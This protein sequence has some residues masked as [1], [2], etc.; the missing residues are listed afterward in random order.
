MQSNLPNK[1]P[2]VS[3]SDLNAK[4]AEV[5]ALMT[6]LISSV[7]VTPSTPIA[8]QNPTMAVE[9]MTAVAMKFPLGSI[10]ALTEAMI[11]DPDAVWPTSGEMAAMLRDVSI[12]A[13]RDSGRQM[14]TKARRHGENQC[15]NGWRYDQI[16][17][18][19]DQGRRAMR[20]GKPHSFLRSLIEGR[21]DL[22]PELA[23]LPPT[24]KRSSLETDVNL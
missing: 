13:F 24:Q 9:S 5:S 15:I 20:S 4:M 17:K 2:N 10:R 19:T 8:R 16:M 7:K 18:A 12:E 3:G 6:K 22:P 23:W 14:S 11:K 1:S 21:E